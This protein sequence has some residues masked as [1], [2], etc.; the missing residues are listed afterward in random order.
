MID[1][2]EWALQRAILERPD[3]PMMFLVYADWL[4]ERGQEDRA[5]LLRAV[6]TMPVRI[7]GP[8]HT[9]TAHIEAIHPYRYELFPWPEP[10]RSAPYVVALITEF[11]G[12][13]K[14]REFWVRTDGT[15]DDNDAWW[16]WL[17]ARAVACGWPMPDRET[18]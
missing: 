9:R 11:Q 10:R 17:L 18:A 7:A 1:E 15:T 12:P 3:E 4:E 13:I 2:D 14:C 8:S 16:G 6:P 5:A